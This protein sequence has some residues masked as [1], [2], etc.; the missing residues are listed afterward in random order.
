[1][2]GDKAR[3]EKETAGGRGIR[4]NLEDDEGVRLFDENENIDGEEFEDMV[5]YE[6]IDLKNIL[7]GICECLETT[8][9]SRSLKNP[10]ESSPPKELSPTRPLDPVT[11]FFERMRVTECPTGSYILPEIP[12]IGPPVNPQ[13]VTAVGLWLTECSR[14]QEGQVGPQNLRHFMCPNLDGKTR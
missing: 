13:T 12:G 9:D 5:K 14:R 7:E 2:K 4:V 8:K 3:R 10:P 11:E 1:M 6:T